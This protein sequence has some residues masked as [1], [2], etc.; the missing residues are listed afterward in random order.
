MKNVFVEGLQGMGKS[1]LLQKLSEK[2]PTYQVCR[3]GDYCPV[4]LA[5][6]SYLTEQEYYQILDKFLSIKEEI[7]K[8]T[9]KE[10][11]NYIVMYTRIIT[12]EPGFHKYMEQYEIYNGRKSLAEFEAIILKRYRN[13]PKSD[14][15]FECVLFQNI[16]EDLILFHQ[17]HDDQISQLYKRIYEILEQKEF[18]ILYLYEEN[19]EEIITHICNERSDEKG[20]KLWYQLM[21]KY[22]E[23]SPY[24]KANHLNGFEG[25]LEHLKHRQQLELKI[26]E[27]TFEGHAI[28]L[29]AKKYNIEQINIR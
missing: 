5:W 19:V 8:W 15:I 6:C 1:M 17:M 10:E 21:L 11:D 18:T 14:N 27:E 2:Y 22:V 23:E 26:I 24:G 3:E 29:P 12:D 20:N 9:V 25:L 4:E 13:L 16:V 7:K 28:V